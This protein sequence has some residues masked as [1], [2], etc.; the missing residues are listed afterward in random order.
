MFFLKAGKITDHSGSIWQREI[1]LQEGN[2]PLPIY[3]FIL[4]EWCPLWKAVIIAINKINLLRVI[5]LTAYI[6][7]ISLLKIYFYILQFSCW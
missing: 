5:F 1:I 6:T 2:F 4:T 7:L 3:M